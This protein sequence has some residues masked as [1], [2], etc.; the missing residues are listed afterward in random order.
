MPKAAAAAD[1]AASSSSTVKRRYAAKVEKGENAWRREWSGFMSGVS[2]KEL[3]KGGGVVLPKAADLEAA[4]ETA[5]GDGGGCNYAYLF[6][7]PTEKKAERLAKQ[8]A[9]DEKRKQRALQTQQAKDPLAHLSKHERALWEAQHR[10]LKVDGMTRKEVRQFLHLTV[11]KEQEEAERHQEE[12]RPHELMDAKL[13][14]YQQGPHPI[15]IIAEKLVTRKA[16]KKGKQLG[17]RYNYLMPHP[18]WLARREQRR[19]ERVLVGLGRRYVFDDDGRMRDVFGAPAGIAPPAEHMT[20]SSS[21]SS[22]VT[23]AV[24]DKEDAEG[25][26]QIGAAQREENFG[27]PSI[28][29]API[30]GSDVLLDPRQACTSFVRAVVRDRKVAAAIKTANITTSYI[31]SS[32]VMGPSI[33]VEEE[34][35]APSAAALPKRGRE[36]H[37]QRAKT[38]QRRPRTAS[39]EP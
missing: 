28:T 26:V 20:H 34:G 36:A 32:L 5:E 13:Q 23:E 17:L 12:F 21:D 33:G 19:R 27:I 16:A 22:K 9:E 37:V 3:R 30:I 2:L 25:G 18:S 14:W 29:A 1:A 15:D 4:V 11:S 10:G 39:F 35:A 6:A 24:G 31:S 38:A 7:S 8:R